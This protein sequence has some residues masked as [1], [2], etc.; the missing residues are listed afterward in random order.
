[1]P[2]GKKHDVRAKPLGVSDVCARPYS[3]S[4]GLNADG[5][6]ASRIGVDSS[7]GYG[8]SAQ[9]GLHVLLHGGEKAV[10]VDMKNPEL[11]HVAIPASLR[12]APMFY[13]C[14]K[15]SGSREMDRKRQLSNVAFGGEWSEAIPIQEVIQEALD[16]LR[17]A[18]ARCD[19]E[20]PLTE[21]VH[22]ALE[23]LAQ[24]VVRGSLIKAAFLE[25]AVIADPSLRAQELSRCLLNLERVLGAEARRQT[26]RG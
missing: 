4:L 9:A 21:E 26:R 15:D 22:A 13:L 2:R 11:A 12:R 17:M 24:R 18:V 16:V 20:N 6:T 3:I 25:A 8:P 1:M 19:E 14:S 23:R 7:D 5:Y 10:H